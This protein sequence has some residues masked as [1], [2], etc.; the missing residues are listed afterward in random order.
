MLATVGKT[1]ALANGSISIAL[2][3]TA[4][5]KKGKKK[6]AYYNKAEQRLD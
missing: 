1:G 6:Y 4:T 5:T 3:T 2:T